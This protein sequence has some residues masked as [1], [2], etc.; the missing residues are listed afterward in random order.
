MADL[1]VTKKLHIYHSLYRLN[2]SFAAIVRRCRDLQEAQIFRPKF[3]RLFQ[4]YAQELQAEIN[5]ELLEVL[6]DVELDDYARFGKIRDARDK[7]LRDPD[8]VFIAARERR[9]ELRRQ[10]KK[11]SG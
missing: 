3:L 6:H 4:G 2:L 1:D 10:K 11:R 8:D 9:E 7:E 5:E